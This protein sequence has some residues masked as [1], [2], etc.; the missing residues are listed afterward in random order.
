MG[1]AYS[2][3]TSSSVSGLLVDSSGAAVP[4]TECRLTN[5]A[6]GNA[7]T[8]RTSTDGAFTFPTVFAG[9]YTFSVHVSGFKS[10]FLKDIP[11]TAGE[12]HAL[13]RIVLEIGDVRESVSVTTESTPVQLMSAERSGLVTGTQL[14]NIAL[15]G[16]DFFAFL[17]T[18]PGIV[19]TN[20][21]RQST[22]NA[23]NGGT[24]IN[25]ARDNQ[26][27]FSVDGITDMDTGANQSLGYEPNMDAIAEVKVLTGNYQAEYGRNSGGTVSVITKSGTREL[28]GSAYDYYRHED[29]NANDFFNNR[30]GT[31]IQPYRYRITGFS[32]GGPVFVPHHFNADKQKFFF[33]FSQEFTGVR[34]NYSPMFVNVPTAAERTGDFSQSRDVNGALIPIRDPTTNQPF[35]GNIVPQ[36]R[37]SDLGKSILNF[38][39]LPNYRDSDPRNLY[40][41]N[42]RSVYSGQLNRRNDV[43]RFDANLS[44][45]LQLYYRYGHDNH[46][47]YIPWGNFKTGSTNY[48]LS[49]VIARSPGTGQLVHL[50]KT[51]SSTLVNETI[52]AYNPAKR[53][54]D[55]QDPELFARS[56]MG[57]PPQQF[58]GDSSGSRAYIPDVSFGG[59]PASPVQVGLYAAFPYDYFNRNYSFADNVN[60]VWGAHNLK[61]G[62]YIERVSMHFLASVKSRGAFN[63]SR[64]TNN[65]FDTNDSFSNA[66]IGNFDTYTEASAALSGRNVVRNVE[67]YVQDNWRISK[68]LTLDY[69]LRI[70]HMPPT[71]DLTNSSATF[72][73]SLYNPANAPLLYRPGTSGGQRVA[74][75]PRTG[76]ATYATLIGLYVPGTGNPANGSAVAGVNGYPSSLVTRP[77]LSY[78]PRFGFAY[79]AF[80]TGKTA[81]RGGFGM[82]HDPGQT[83]PLQSSLGNP[84]TLYSPVLYYGN[85]NTFTQ[86]A[87]AIGPSSLPIIFGNAS[88]P[89][90]MNYSLGIQ[91]QVKGV[92]IDTA[93]VGSQSRHLQ[94]SQNIN[95]IPMF[96]RFDPQNADPTQAGKPLPDNFFRPYRGYGD[97]TFTGWNGTSN[98]NSLQ[99]SV[100]RRYARGFQFGVAYTF[101]KALGAGSADGEAMS[102]YFSPRSRNYGP[103]NFDRTHN[104]VI[105]YIYDF[106]KLSRDLSWRPAHWVAD[107]WQLSGITSFI[108]GAPF[109]PSFSTTDGAD[110]TG[111]TEG[112]RITVVGDPSL[113][114]DQRNFYHNF[115]TAAF[116]R[117]PRGSFGN[118]GLNYMR[119]PGTNN[120]DVALAKRFPLFSEA[121]FIQ[122]RFEAFNAWNHTQFASYFTGAKFDPSGAQID[123]NFGAYASTRSPR[124]IQLS[125]RVMF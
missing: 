116:A 11:V 73:P 87:G 20:G 60:K 39:P 76:Q 82:F 41:Y 110:I 124:V 22:G 67:F 123:P 121:R 117:T 103:L 74:V 113:D 111:S 96:G 42:Y 47:E 86:T 120:W 45:T 69:G 49:P 3:N 93:Y 125:L 115:N 2:Q 63:F 46:V 85:L 100:S 104:L 26:K 108:S 24:F 17:A 14:N 88:L 13:G 30:T 29:L 64:D 43:L 27:N 7:V 54:A 21:S 52:A 44:P 99:I 19:D 61:A 4:N 9:A 81:L 35:P 92:L 28:H 89:T 15:K 72:D 48:L 40:R 16:R 65:P 1:L 37:I 5:Q 112:P 94:V 119:G 38:F 10:F 23:A 31:P 59:Q 107:N 106:P 105:N 66:L 6:T 98:Y 70:Y 57:N 18:I 8:A 36:N 78:G 75:D 51:F 95:P 68:R 79:D 12:I 118:G 55:Y 91:Q 33:F 83:N 102:P 32:V 80:G 122:F 25:G 56:R 90:T 114:K 109:T 58:P 101:S 50:T 97:L 77:A 71:P 84:P 62:V 53:T 34:P